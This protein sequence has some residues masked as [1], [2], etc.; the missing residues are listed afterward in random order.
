MPT[1]I[2]AAVA[3]ISRRHKNVPSPQLICRPR[4]AKTQAKS[5]AKLPPPL[6]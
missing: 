1:K 5:Q 4:I 3:A 6:F 2:A